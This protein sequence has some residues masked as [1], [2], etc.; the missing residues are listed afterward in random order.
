MWVHVGSTYMSNEFIGT[1]IKK[2]QAVTR[3]TTQVFVLVFK[4][5]FTLCF[6]VSS[7]H[8]HNHTSPKSRDPGLS[9]HDP[10]IRSHNDPSTPNRKRGHDNM[11]DDVWTEHTSSS[12]RVYYYNKRL[13]KSQW[14]RPTGFP[15]KKYE[16]IRVD[17]SSCMYSRQGKL[18]SQFIVTAHM[19]FQ[20]S[21]NFFRYNKVNSIALPAPPP[22]SSSDPS[23]SLISV[24][25]LSDLEVRA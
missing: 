15:M 23:S 18:N 24:W 7:N 16:W 1:V 10:D 21:S 22:S 11:E 2:L 25:G 13:D 9:S 17:E 19:D 8:V 6:T 12:G 3:I 5:Y 14:E 20:I 4:I